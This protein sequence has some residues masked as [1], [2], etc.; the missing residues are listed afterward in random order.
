MFTGGANFA[1]HRFPFV[2]LH[3]DNAEIITGIE[4]LIDKGTIDSCSR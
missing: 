4:D 3:F 2:I 1:S